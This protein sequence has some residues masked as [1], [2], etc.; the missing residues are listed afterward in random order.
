MADLK[1]LLLYPLNFK[2]I[3]SPLVIGAASVLA[4]TALS[5]CNASKTLDGLTPGETLTQGYVIDQEQIDLVPVGSSREQVLLALGT[6]ST[7]A[8]F[9]NEVFYYISQTRKRPVAF[10]NP[11]LVDQRVLAVYFGEDGRVTQIANYGKQ[12]GKVFDF[13]S[14][15]TPTGGKDQTFIGQL[16]AGAGGRPTSLPG[17][18]RQ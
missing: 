10:A 18:P 8:T 3:F 11:R 16:I 17:L 7:T 5:G 13:I 6:P 12:D 9:D 1:E 14:R 2:T 15:T 4:A